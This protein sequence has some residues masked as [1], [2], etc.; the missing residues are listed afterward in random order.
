ME[1]C[2][3]ERE[4]R[5]RVGAARAQNE[6]RADPEHDDPHV[7]DRVQREQTLQV[8]LEQR[9]HDAA[10]GRKRADREHEHAEPHR[11]HPIPFDEYAQEAVQRDLDHHSAHQR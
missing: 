2:G 5:P 10:E 9:I 3:G 6:A 4:R 1:Q 7:L 8:V 11:Q